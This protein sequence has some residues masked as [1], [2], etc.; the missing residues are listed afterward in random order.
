MS[1]L[2][3]WVQSLTKDNRVKVES[4]PLNFE[5]RTRKCLKVREKIA[6]DGRW[7]VCAH[8]VGERL[9]GRHPMSRGIDLDPALPQDPARSQDPLPQGALA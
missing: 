2:R 8:S 6:F 5:N 9:R 4:I 7:A 3:F 1:L